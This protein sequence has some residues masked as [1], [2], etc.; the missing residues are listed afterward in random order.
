MEGQV[1]VPVV[2]KTAGEPNCSF[3]TSSE[4]PRQGLRRTIPSLPRPKP[5]SSRILVVPASTAPLAGHPIHVSTPGCAY[6]SHDWQGIATGRWD[7]GQIIFLPS[8]TD[9]AETTAPCGR[10]FRTFSPESGTTQTTE[11]PTSYTGHLQ[12]LGKEGLGTISSSTR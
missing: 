10:P 11:T 8:P 7:G 1:H 9:G 2:S 4:T 12:G 3:Y 5:G 6:V